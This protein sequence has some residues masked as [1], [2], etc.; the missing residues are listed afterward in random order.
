MN[1]V[2]TYD[3]IVSERVV[4]VLGNKRT[5]L[6]GKRFGRLTVIEE[7]D[8]RKWG[9]VVWLL[10]CECG[11]KKKA[12]AQSFTSG[13]T[14]SCGCS[15]TKTWQEKAEKNIGKVY[16]RLTVVKP[17]KKREGKYKMQYLCKCD[18]GNETVKR[19]DLLKSGHTVS[20]GCYHKEI[21]SKENSHFYKEFLTEA[22]RERN[23]YT[24]F[25]DKIYNWRKEVYERDNYACKVCG[26]GGAKKSN[27]LNAHHLNGWN[28]FEPGRFDVKNGVTL[29]R[30]CHSDFH[31]VYGYGDNTKEQFEE[32]IKAL[33]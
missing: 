12:V 33:A 10:E 1:S 19:L 8:E 5:D 13:N 21:V 18:C 16:G 14:V 27:N 11:N 9:N 24:L 26:V 23:R 2:I 30:G 29:C 31:S 32:Y 15:R 25:G 4:F 3:T 22:D 6:I 28:W 20:C 17:L 7:T